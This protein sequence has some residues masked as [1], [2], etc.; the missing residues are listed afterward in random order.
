MSVYAPILSI[1][2]RHIEHYDQDPEKIF[3]TEGLSRETIADTDLRLP[4]DLVDRLRDKAA[5][6]SGDSAFGL[7]AAKYWHPSHMGA[8]GYAWILAH[9]LSE[10]LDT[11]CRYSRMVNEA[12]IMASTLYGSELIVE[13]SYDL[14]SVNS[15]VREDSYASMLMSMC[16]ANYG[17]GFNPKRVNLEHSKPDDVEP[18]EDLFRCPVSFNSDK[19]RIVFTKEQAETP[20][21]IANEQLRQLNLDLVKK[22][23][24]QLD[25]PSFISQV[26]AEIL[27]E[28]PSGKVT[29]GTIAKA[30]HMTSRTLQRNL[31]TEAVTFKSLLTEVRTELAKQYIR[32][33][34]LNLTEI[35]FLLGFSETSS[36]SRA[37]KGWTGV[38][39]S[40]TRMNT[41]A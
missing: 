15:Y 40:A 32:D 34:C 9:T 31:K 7:K 6:Q 35:S 2:W 41:S 16:H 14:P 27:R 37:Y 38:S 39:P 33:K 11:S 1:L 24:A 22:Y 10:G 30:L 28:L 8:L 3:A 5:R 17:L 13:V 23:L 12:V 29:D 36:F 19:T 25:N 4:Y 21:L 18:Y 20:S 26:R